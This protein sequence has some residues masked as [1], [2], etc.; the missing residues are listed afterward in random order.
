MNPYGNKGYAQ[1]GQGYNQPGQGQWGPGQ[2]GQGQWGPGQQHH[3]PQGQG[4]GF[5]QLSQQY[6]INQGMIQ[7]SGAQI[8]QQSDND[9][10]GTLNFQE[11]QNAVFRFCQQNGVQPPNPLDYQQLF[12]YFDFDKSGVLDFGEFKML[13]EQ[14]GGIRQYSQ[15]DLTGFRCQRGQR[16][17]QYQ[18]GT[19]CKLF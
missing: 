11:G 4:M 8:F 18:Q 16:I 10:S 12:Q 7:N 14:L 13:L 6:N 2:Q 17:G 19:S 5:P 1:P 9:R 3:H 15:Q